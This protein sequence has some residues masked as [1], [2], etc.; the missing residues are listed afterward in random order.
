MVFSSHSANMSVVTVTFASTDFFNLMLSLF[1]G[2]FFYIVDKSHWYAE[3][4][5]RISGF[6]R[7]HWP[8]SDWDERVERF[9]FLIQF[10]I[11]WSGPWLL[12]QIV[13]SDSLP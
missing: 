13:S 10:L 4:C 9:S 5:G 3:R 2:I 8:K 1:L 6:F 7:R 12:S 11:C